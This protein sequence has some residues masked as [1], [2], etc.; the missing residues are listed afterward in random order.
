MRLVHA[1]DVDAVLAAGQSVALREQR[2]H[3]LPVLHHQNIRVVHDDELERR[4]EIAGGLAGLLELGHEAERRAH[5]WAKHDVNEIAL[6]IRENKNT[7]QHV[8]S[9]K[10]DV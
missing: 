5:L 9:K 3:V 1:H 7:H 8:G 10:V 4:E 6:P 2:Q